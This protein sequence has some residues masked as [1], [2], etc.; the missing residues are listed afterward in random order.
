MKKL[1]LFF[2]VICTMSWVSIAYAESDLIEGLEENMET[3]WLKN[4]FTQ[5][6]MDDMVEQQQQAFIDSFYSYPWSITETMWGV[7]GLTQEE[8]LY[9]H[10]KQRLPHPK[11]GI[12]VYLMNTN[13][14]FAKQYMYY[15]DFE[16]LISDNYYWIVPQTREDCYSTYNQ[17]GKFGRVAIRKMDSIISV[18]EK[19]IVDFLRDYDKINLLLAEK[20]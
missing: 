7:N 16:Y 17:N 14:K 6:Q 18:L 19:E 5:E 3:L 15:D 2:I 4:Y 1:A 8:T 9:Y 10:L 12:R 20:K 11:D 13:L